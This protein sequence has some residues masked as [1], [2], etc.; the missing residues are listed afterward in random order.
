MALV[1]S[2]MSKTTRF[3]CQ[4]FLLFVVACSNGKQEFG[5]TAM[6]VKTAKPATAPTDANATAGESSIDQKGIIDV[7]KETLARQAEAA[8]NLV[9]AKIFEASKIVS[10]ES[11]FTMGSSTASTN[12]TLQRAESNQI[13][14]FNQITR[15][16]VTDSFTQGVTQTENISG[17]D[18]GLLDILLVIDD[19][20]SMGEEQAK[21]AA[22]L[23]N[24]VEQ[25]Q[26]NNWQIGVITTTAGGADC[27][28]NRATGNSSKCPGNEAGDS[29]VDNNADSFGNLKALIK[30]GDPNAFQTLSTVISGLGTSG[31]N[32]ER[33]IL[34]S[35]VG[36]MPKN[37]L[38][39]TD[40]SVAVLIVSDEDNCGSGS[41]PNLLSGN[42]NWIDWLDNTALPSLGL[43]RKVG[44]Q[45]GNTAFFGLLYDESACSTTSDERVGVEY[46]KIMR[47]HRPICAEDYTEILKQISAEA[48]TVLQSKWE[49]KSEPEVGSIRVYMD[50]VL[51][52]DGFSVSGKILSFSTAPALDAMIRVE[53]TPKGSALPRSSF[54]LAKKALSG[55]VAVKVNG[56]DVNSNEYRVSSASPSVLT[57][58][59]QP[60]NSASISVS[61]KEDKPLTTSFSFTSGD[62]KAGSLKVLVNGTLASS[63]AGYSFDATST[64][65]KIT[66]VNAPPEGASVEATFVEL[67]NKILTYPVDLGNVSGVT[68]S[69]AD[70]P[71][72]SLTVTY[73]ATAR[74]VTFQENQ[75]VDGLDVKVS[76]PIAMVDGAYPLPVVPLEGSVSVTHASGSCSASDLSVNENLLT[77]G[78]SCAL[79]PGTSFTVAYRTLTDI[80]TS[81]DMGPL[82]AAYCDAAKWEFWVNGEVLTSF[83]REGCAFTSTAALVN[84]AVVK[85]VGTGR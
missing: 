69:K 39:R 61:Y 73:N 13:R 51:L 63:P 50:D 4:G 26:G 49:L 54:T 58:T 12:V 72:V 81:F 33:G 23:S 2:K 36:L 80:Q 46:K 6:A 59:S 18:L 65:N 44:D 19:S 30:K 40:S 3:V 5:A 48:R 9:V 56:V 70:S 31:D 76:Y 25:V 14:L 27:V 57:F 45:D 17:R 35:Y 77:L 41:C 60:P 24:I 83:S 75:F 7:I 16:E 85:I 1:D 32:V 15:P 28:A 37:K 53:Y 79:A 55:S 71:T 43:K 84:G 82:E 22:K 74:T 34:Q 8:K 62:V 67:G 47:L 68:A 21:L 42:N 38:V 52:S 11:T 29:S 66:F 10:G 20:I 78:S 64:P